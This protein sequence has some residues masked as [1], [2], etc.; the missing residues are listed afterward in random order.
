MTVKALFTEKQYRTLAGLL[1]AHGR[2]LD[3]E[4]A[5]EGE[6]RA[7]D[8]AMAALQIGA[9]KYA[10]WASSGQSARADFEPFPVVSVSAAA[11]VRE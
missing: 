11:A 5:S 7:W 4:A 6:S 2:L 10:T 8:G 3:S 9:D 1:K